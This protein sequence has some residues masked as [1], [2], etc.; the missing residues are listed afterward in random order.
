[1]PLS[2]VQ[3]ATTDIEHAGRRPASSGRRLRRRRQW[4]A[5]RTSLRLRRQSEPLGVS[6][7]RASFGC[8]FVFHLLL[9]CKCLSGQPI[10]ESCDHWSVCVAHSYLKSGAVLGDRICIQGVNPCRI[11]GLGPYPW[12]QAHVASAWSAQSMHP[13]LTCLES[14]GSGYICP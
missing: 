7:L 11:C 5:C 4:P 8:A 6:I 12:D 1:M 14:Q 2:G 13:L 3:L 10:R 9:F